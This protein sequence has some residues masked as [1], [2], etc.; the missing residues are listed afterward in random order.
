M[1]KILEKISNFF[2]SKKSIHY[3][4]EQEITNSRHDLIN[5]CYE[6]LNKT[7]STIIIPRSYVVA[8]NASSTI[9]TIVHLIN[10]THH[11]R[12]L[13]YED[14]L[15][16]IIGFIHIKDVLN[17][18]SQKSSHNIKTLIRKPLSVTSSM[19]LVDLL[20]LMKQERIHIAVVIDE[21]G[22][23]DGIATIDDIIEVMI[24]PI[25]DEH[26]YNK[27][28]NYQVID[29]ITY[30]VNARAKISEI[31]NLININLRRDNEDC[32]TIGGLILARSGHMLAAGSILKI[33][34][35]VKIEVIDSD[36]RSIK[37]IKL[38]KTR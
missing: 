35:N 1:Y 15:D 20:S 23:M 32:D 8:I 14:E 4:K 21:Y 30:I 28:P 33:N 18:L 11:T 36:K 7:V 26:D 24:G 25:D 31:E 13:V 9:E 10:R 38:I 16:N 29:D 3:S 17:F 19:K 37:Q 22:G 6:F 27:V 2:R 12:I 34:E 5:K